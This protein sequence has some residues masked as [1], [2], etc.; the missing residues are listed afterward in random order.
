MLGDEAREQARSEVEELDWLGDGGR[1]R[2][3][4]AV[5]EPVGFGGGCPYSPVVVG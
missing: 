3:M 2:E 1:E 5:E 4:S